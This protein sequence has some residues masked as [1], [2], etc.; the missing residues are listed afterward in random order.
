MPLTRLW[1]TSGPTPTWGCPIPRGHRELAVTDHTAPPKWAQTGQL[2]AS[3]LSPLHTCP[4]W[5][6]KLSSHPGVG[7]HVLG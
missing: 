5:L 7:V 2:G 3:T 1:L 6:R 4:T